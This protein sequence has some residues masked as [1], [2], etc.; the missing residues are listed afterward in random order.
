MQQVYL[1]LLLSGANARNN[2]K[3]YINY[4]GVIENEEY[5]AKL[6][7]NDTQNYNE[8]DDE[9]TSPSLVGNYVQDGLVVL[10]D[11]EKNVGTSHSN[12]SDIWKDLSGNDNNATLSDFEFSDK[13]GWIYNG[14]KF[15]GKEYVE[16][17]DFDF[18]EYTIEIVAKLENLDNEVVTEQ[19]LISNLNDGGYGILYAQQNNLDDAKKGR[20]GFEAYK[21]KEEEADISSVYSDNE[22][23]ENKIYSISI[24]M[25]DDGLG[26]IKQLYTE[27]G[28]IKGTTL[29][30][31]PK[32]SATGTKLTL[33]AKPY[34]GVI[35]IPQFVGTI[36]SVRVYNRA[37]TEEE[38]SKNFDVDK[39][40]YNIE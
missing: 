15:T 39:E 33:G 10:L 23:I 21:T 40:K 38:I 7:D 37:L 30:G 14:L 11:G 24:T 19:S 17:K 16:L 27:N 8:P 12:N 25:G 3:V 18:E 13:S 29:D 1:I 6:I 34:A 26:G 9:E 32:D 35:P 20:I 5:R 36:Y 22:A 4:G 28:I 31:T 2:T